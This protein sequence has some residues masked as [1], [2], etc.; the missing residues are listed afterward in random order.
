MCGTFGEARGC[1]SGCE[2]DENRAMSADPDI[3]IRNDAPAP[4][5]MRPPRSELETAIRRI[6]GEAAAE[7][8]PPH[9]VE[10]VRRLATRTE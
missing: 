8:L 3:P 1:I 7:P 4:S 6:Y 5:R 9:L 2:S 10:L